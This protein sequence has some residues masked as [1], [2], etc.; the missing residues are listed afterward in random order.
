MT[1]VFEEDI[2]FYLHMCS[3]QVMHVLAIKL[4]DVQK[5]YATEKLGRNLGV[6]HM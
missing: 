1:V 3:T 4:H 2:V 5:Q 6:R